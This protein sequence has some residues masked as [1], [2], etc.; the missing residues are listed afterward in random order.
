MS[1]AACQAHVADTDLA[2]TVIARSDNILS[3]GKV[4]VERMYEIEA[5]KYCPKTGERKGPSVICSAEPMTHKEACTV[6]SKFSHY[7]GRRVQLREVV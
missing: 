4:L 2:L 6:L 5:F 3:E 1:V 7:A